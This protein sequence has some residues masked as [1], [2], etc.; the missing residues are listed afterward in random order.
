MS[1]L[2]Q[3]HVPLVGGFLLFVVIFVVVHG[4]E[5]RP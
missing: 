1:T 3:L 4:R 5:K 2:Y